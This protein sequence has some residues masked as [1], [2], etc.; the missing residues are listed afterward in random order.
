MNIAKVKDLKNNTRGIHIAEKRN[1]NARRR[2]VID[3]RNSGKDTASSSENTDKK[4]K[5]YIMKIIIYGKEA[6]RLNI[7]LGIGSLRFI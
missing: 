1:M 6:D 5:E 3:I 2:R 7:T 4:T